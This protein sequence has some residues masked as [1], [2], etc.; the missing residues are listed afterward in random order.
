MATV[1]LAT[2]HSLQRKVAI[3]VLD[4]TLDHGD[5]DFNARFINEALL[6]ASLNHPRIIT[7]YDVATIDDCRPYI[8]MEFLAGGDLKQ[9]LTTPL[10]VAKATTIVQHIIEGLETLHAKGVIH[11]DIK[12]A[13]ILFRE[14][15]SAVITDFGI[16]KGLDNDTDL[17]QVG[18]SVGSPSYSSPEQT[19]CK[20]L[21]QRSDIYSLGVVLLEMLQGTNPFKG[22]S[23]TDTAVNH[24]QM[25]LPT[26]Q[27]DLL[28]LQPLLEQM[29]AKDPNERFSSCKELSAALSAS[30]SRE[31]TT[32]AIVTPALE[33][34]SD[35]ES[36]Q[37]RPALRIPKNLPFSIPSSTYYTIGFI[38]LLIVGYCGL[39]YQSP[40]DQKIEAYL[41]QANTHFDNGQLIAPPEENARYF[42]RQVLLLDEENDDANE[43]LDDIIQRQVEDF[44]ALAITRFE[45]QQLMQPR[46]DNAV[47]YYREALALDPNNKQAVEGLEHIVEE[48]VHLAQSAFLQKQYD[49]GFRYVNRGLSIN[50]KQTELLQLRIQYRKYSNSVKRLFNSIFD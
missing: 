46:K 14:D 38:I 45:E 24:L 17:T 20:E 8:V 4:D 42:Y 28:Y 31:A 49:Q 22:P 25:A 21:D 5:N 15:G 18:V 7:I 29:L 40:L 11:R 41:E 34:T 44:N 32:P 6:I 1:Y 12:P 16:A 50:S 23:H 13:N 48:Y 37:I 39:I 27:E 26:L 19:Q 9:Y 3:K 30:M 33:H 36:T 47:F 10:S 43:G 2:Q 35:Q